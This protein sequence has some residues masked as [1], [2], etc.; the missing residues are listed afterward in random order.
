MDTGVHFNGIN[1]SGD[2][3]VAIIFQWNSSV[4]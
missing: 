1:I 3:V 2:P 4:Q